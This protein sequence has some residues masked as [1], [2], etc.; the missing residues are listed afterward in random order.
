MNGGHL[1]RHEVFHAK[2]GVDEDV[3]W[4]WAK[5][6]G[7]KVQSQVNITCP[8]LSPPVLQGDPGE[9]TSVD[10]EEPMF[11]RCLRCLWFYNFLIFSLHCDGDGWVLQVLFNMCLFYWNIEKR[12]N[13]QGNIV[14]FVDVVM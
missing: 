12:Q 6:G 8:H 4:R 7:A 10:Y 2:V 9:G 13:I 14:Q 5:L 1:G 11:L 3:I